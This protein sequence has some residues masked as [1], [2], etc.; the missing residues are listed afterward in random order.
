MSFEDIKAAITSNNYET[1][2]R[3]ITENK[4][5]VNSRDNFNRT[6][7]YISCYVDNPNLNIVQLLVENG[8]ALNNKDT[9]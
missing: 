5:I 4:E 6:P 7:L 8:A 3:L 1:V 2:A 9:I